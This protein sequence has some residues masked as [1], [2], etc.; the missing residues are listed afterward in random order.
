V[1]FRAPPARLDVWL[2]WVDRWV[3]YA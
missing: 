3:A 1:V 2:R